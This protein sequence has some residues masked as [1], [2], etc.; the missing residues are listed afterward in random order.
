MVL[1]TK[2][3]YRTM[4]RNNDYVILNIFLSDLF[5]PLSL[6]WRNHVSV[7]LFNINW[8]LPLVICN[9]G[10]FYF[11]NGQATLLSY[12]LK[13]ESSLLPGGTLSVTF[14]ISFSRQIKAAFLRHFPFPPKDICFPSILSR[15]FLCILCHILSE[16][17][18]V[19]I[20]WSLFYL[21]VSSA[22]SSIASC[23]ERDVA[24]SLI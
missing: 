21:S 15:P 5:R 8:C 14:W 1:F 19:L 9:V 3:L 22:L 6:V 16:R 13:I 23:V 11:C 18:H 12:Y 2:P 20:K 10:S 4:E 7:I 24:F 17:K